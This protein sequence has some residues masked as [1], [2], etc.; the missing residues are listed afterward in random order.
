MQA[1]ITKYIG[2]TD[3]KAARIKATCASGSKTVAWDHAWDTGANHRIAAVELATKLG[4][5]GFGFGQ[6]ESGD[7]PNGT[8][9]HVIVNGRD[10]PSATPRLDGANSAK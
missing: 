2:P 5:I 1:I 9:A 3:T 10:T 7:L 8:Y 6:L 4:L